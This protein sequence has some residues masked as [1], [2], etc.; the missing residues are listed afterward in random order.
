MLAQ[1]EQY[2]RVRKEVAIRRIDEF[3]PEKYNQQDNFHSLE[4]VRDQLTARKEQLRARIQEVGCTL[5]A[6]NVTPQKLVTVQEVEAAARREAKLKERLLRCGQ[7]I[8]RGCLL[9]SKLSSLCGE[10][11]LVKREN[12]AGALGSASLVLER[13]RIE[14]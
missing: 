12:V 4:A 13:R 8:D 3:L 5:D 11:A 1:E 9:S 14:A 6:R 7:I 2:S 10:V